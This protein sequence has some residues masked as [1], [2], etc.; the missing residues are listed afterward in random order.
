MGAALSSWLT[1]APSQHS[2]RTTSHLC[3]SSSSGLQ[4][5]YADLASQF[6]RKGFEESGL[7][8]ARASFSIGGDGSGR[9]RMYD[10]TPWTLP[11]NTVRVLA[12]SISDAQLNGP[13]RKVG[14]LALRAAADLAKEL[15]SGTKAWV[16]ELNGLHAT[17]FHPGLAPGTAM[18]PGLASPSALQLDRELHT[19]RRF[20]ASVPGNLSLVVDRLTMTPSGVLL[21]L[22]RPERDGGRVCIESLRAAAAKL[23]PGAAAK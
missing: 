22:L 3:S 14:E 12:L 15:P 2:L 13:E 7:L 6:P 4:A 16:P 11:A 18:R 1:P 23:F 19:A 17:I 5:R 9:P 20:A 8:Q 21:L 10:E